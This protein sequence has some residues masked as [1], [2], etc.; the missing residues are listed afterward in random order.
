MAP[1]TDRHSVP[2]F[3]L[4][5]RCKGRQGHGKVLSWQEGKARVC[6][7]WWKL[8]WGDGRQT[9][10]S[11]VHEVN[12]E[13]RSDF[14]WLVPDWKPELKE[15]TSDCCPRPHHPGTSVAVVRV[16]FPRLIAQEFGV[17]FLGFLGNSKFNWHRS[18]DHC[19]FL[20]PGSQ[21]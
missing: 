20:Y 3:Y 19:L 16:C 4:W 17:W 5:H 21:E 13:G 15:G 11:T 2:G 6:S 14:L 18:C 8:A 9:K 12:W 7:E 10:S 1:A